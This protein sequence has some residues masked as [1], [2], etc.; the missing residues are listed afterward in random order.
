MEQSEKC[1]KISY[2]KEEQYDLKFNRIQ[3]KRETPFKKESD[4]R[5]VFD[6]VPKKRLT[7]ELVSNLKL[8]FK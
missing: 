8:E 5:L 4:P 3:K 2:F 1:F 7:D 6:V